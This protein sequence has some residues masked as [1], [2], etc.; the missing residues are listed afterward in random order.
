MKSFKTSFYLH[1]MLRFTDFIIYKKVIKVKAGD[2]AVLVLWWISICVILLVS[3]IECKQQSNINT[4]E[5]PKDKRP[6]RPFISPQSDWRQLWA[7]GLSYWISDM[8]PHR[9]AN[10]KH[11]MIY[12]WFLPPRNNT[13]P[14]PFIFVENKC[15]RTTTHYPN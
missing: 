2:I 14:S 12:I 3:E 13:G 6:K 10:Y 9:E 4:N 15:G 5:L 1:W 8:T 7:T 11:K